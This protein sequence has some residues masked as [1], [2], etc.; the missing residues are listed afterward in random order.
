MNPNLEQAA[1][2]DRKT[3]KLLAKISLAGEPIQTNGLM[4]DSGI[5]QGFTILTSP[6]PLWD[7]WF[8]QKT[9][10][11]RTHNTQQLARI[12]TYPTAGENQGHLDFIPGTKQ[13]YV[14]MDRSRRRVKPKSQARRWLVMLQ[15]L[16]SV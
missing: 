3:G 2:L 5:L 7:A 6:R 4:S 1:L 15:A 9:V 14:G 13:R 10:L 16:L 11:L 8:N 12:A